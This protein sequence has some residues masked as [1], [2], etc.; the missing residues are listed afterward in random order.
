MPYPLV[1]LLWLHN[2]PKKHEYHLKHIYRNMP[3][4]VATEFEGL[5]TVVPEELPA[6]IE[7]PP[8]LFHSTLTAILAADDREK[9]IR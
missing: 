8:A 5:Y 2:Y 7:R 9:G 4:E 6:A 1:E 3:P